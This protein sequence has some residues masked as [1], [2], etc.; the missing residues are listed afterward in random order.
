ML[1]ERSTSRAGSAQL[2]V[3]YEVVGVVVEQVGQVAEFP[4][5]NPLEVTRVTNSRER[6]PSGL[7]NTSAN[8]SCVCFAVAE[9]F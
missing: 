9:A 2:E 3:R 4:I 6:T 1:T 5:L 8:T 7:P